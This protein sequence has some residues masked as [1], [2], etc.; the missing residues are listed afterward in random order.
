MGCGSSKAT[1][2]VPASQAWDSTGTKTNAKDVREGSSKSRKSRKGSAGKSSRVK[3]LSGSTSSIGSLDSSSES[4]RE[5]RLVSSATSK[6]SNKSGD[7]GLGDDYAHVITESSNPSAVQQVETERRPKTPDFELT[8]QA[9]SRTRSGKQRSEDI[10]RQLQQEGLVRPKTSGGGRSLAFEVQLGPA[11]KLPPVNQ[12]PPPRLAKLER[13]RKKKKLTKEELEE[14]MRKAEER[15]QRKEQE[16]RE[17]AIQTR[18]KETTQDPMAA[19]AEHQKELA[20]KVEEKVNEAEKKREAHLKA[21]RDR[22]RQ[23]EEHAKKVREAKLKA[24]ENPPQDMEIKEDI[25]AT[26]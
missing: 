20:E 11:N 17:K 25:T 19:F 16:V 7:S 5:N 26:S 12:L 2:V 23:K 9:I 24:L 8:G 14:K 21:L 22:L 4:D 3:R 15:R 18:I 10:L 6:A 13:R 1:Q